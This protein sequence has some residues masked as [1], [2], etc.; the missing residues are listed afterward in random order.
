MN[1]TQSFLIHGGNGKMQVPS[2]GTVMPCTMKQLASVQMVEFSPPCEMGTIIQRTQRF[3][4]DT[5][6]EVV[7]ASIGEQLHTQ[8][9]NLEGR[10]YMQGREHNEPQGVF[11][12]NRI[13]R[14]QAV[15]SADSVIDLV[16]LLDARYRSSGAF[17]CCPDAVRDLKRLKDRDGRFLYEDSLAAGVPARLIGYPCHTDPD[18][19]DKHLM[20][21]DF[22][23]GYVIQG[24]PFISILR[25][26]F[27][28]KP[29]VLFH[30]THKTGGMVNNGEAL[31]IMEYT[32]ADEC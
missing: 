6:P 2:H 17:L 31:K 28:Q 29:H 15:L 20:F 9:R 19:P 3:L 23:E 16:Y 30:A 18:A 7:E 12:S 5:A 27:G 10:A 11:A 24:R 4:D 21:G 22:R 25:D 26:P 32:D 8:I 1:P 13:Q 14:T